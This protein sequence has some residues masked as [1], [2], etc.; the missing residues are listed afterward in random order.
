MLNIRIADRVVQVQANY[1]A[2]ENRCA[3]YICDEKP[4][5]FVSIC[6]ADIAFE[7][8]KCAREDALEG[9]MIRRMTD[10][11]LE[12][13]AVQR[14]I[15]EKLFTYDTI[16]LHGSVVAVDGAAYLFTA[17]SGTGKSTHTALWCDLFGG[18][19]V[20]V[21]DDKPFLRITEDGILAYGSPWNGK[22]GR[23][24]NICVP[25]K[26]I[27]ILQRGTQNQIRPIA[28]KEALFTLLQQTNRPMDP[29]QMPKYLEL[30]DRL[31]KQMSF[32]RMTCNMDPEAARMAYGTM[33][34]QENGM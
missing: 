15:A 30:I 31:T 3:E 19:A 24:S 4:D 26:A 17:K 27:C 18:R 6:A 10:A 13:T 11:Q 5:F 16:L 2:V 8:S 22:H 12:I 33:S 14:K 28:A 23:G 20:M 1:P 21:N 29:A 9:R 32:Y 7:R 25:L 34:G